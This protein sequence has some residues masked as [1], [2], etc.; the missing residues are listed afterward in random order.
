MIYRNLLVEE[1]VSGLNGP[2][3][4]ALQF[5]SQGYASIGHMVDTD[6]IWKPSCG[7]ASSPSYVVLDGIVGRPS[8]QISP[9]QLEFLNNNRF[10]VPQIAQLMGVSVSTIR[11]RMQ[12]FNLYIQELDGLVSR[13]Q[14]QFPNWGNSGHK[15]T[16]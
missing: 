4:E 10:S 8:F 12:T 6:C 14:D 2:E 3:R 7:Y 16:K 9:T 15:Y 13:M 5:V 11:R 1:L